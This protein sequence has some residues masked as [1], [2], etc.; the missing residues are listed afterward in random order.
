[1]MLHGEHSIMNNVKL[2]KNVINALAFLLFT[3]VIVMLVY[4]F[5]NSEERNRCIDGIV[6][7]VHKDGSKY[8]VVNN[9]GVQIPCVNPDPGKMGSFGSK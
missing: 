8:A 2:L 1:M 9:V 5:F 6:F 3:G 4:A 7:T